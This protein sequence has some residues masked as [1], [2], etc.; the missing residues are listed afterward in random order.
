MDGTIDLLHRV[1]RSTVTVVAEI[2]ASH[3]SVRVLGTSRLGSGT[4]VDR[5]GTILTANYVVLGAGPVAVVDIEGRR[6]RGELL[7]HDYATGIAAVRIE[8]GLLPPIP[9]GD[10]SALVPGSDVFV[11]ASTGT[12]ERRVAS[13]A[14]ASTE[15]FDAYW[16]YKLERALWLT[17]ANPGLGGGPVCDGHGSLLGVVSLHLGTLG[18]TTLAIPA[19]NYYA[20]ADELRAHGRRISRPQRAWL[21]MFC[22]AFVDRTVIAGLMPGS[23]GDVSGLAAGDVIVSV[24]GIRI[25]D[26]AELYDRIWRHRPGEIVELD[27]V[28]DGELL[29]LPVR[30]VDVDEFFG[31]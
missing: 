10:S 13:G 25:T 20:H 12:E 23:P 17:F 9:R 2:P 19:E 3:P 11:V 16:E 6:H 29:K 7:A 5:N 22:H 15:A 1:V 27:V 30:G 26:R 28:R 24:D 21:G 18:R 4:V 31:G 14:V 8:G